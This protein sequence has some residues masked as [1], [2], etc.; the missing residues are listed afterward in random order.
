MRARVCMCVLCAVCL[1]VCVCVCVC[2]YVCALYV[3]VRVCVHFNLDPR[4]FEV[5]ALLESVGLGQ[6]RQVV[7]T[8]LG[9]PVAPGHGLSHLSRDV[10]LQPNRCSVGGSRFVT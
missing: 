2:R 4:I 1:C 5:V 8:P 9:E 10:I 7:S 6:R 3:C